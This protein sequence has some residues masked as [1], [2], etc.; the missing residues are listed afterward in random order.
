MRNKILLLLGLSAFLVPENATLSIMLLLFS[1]LVA[2]NKADTLNK[3]LTIIIATAGLFMI[4]PAPLAISL[5]TATSL[6]LNHSIL[7]ASLVLVLQTSL[8]GSCEAILSD[9][10]YKVHLEP[11]A[12]SILVGLFLV[13]LAPK[14]AVFNSLVLALSPV[15]IIIF[16]RSMP[17][18]SWLM[19]LGSLPVFYIAQRYLEPN[20]KGANLGFI[21]LFIF[22]VSV[23]WIHAFPRHTSDSYLVIPEASSSPEYK[24]YE[25]YEAVTKFTG[26]NLK[27]VSAPEDI[28][29]NSLVLLPWLTEGFDD[30]DSVMT[31]KI[32]ELA[33]Q[34]K[35]TVIL[36]GEHTNM[37]GVAERINLLTG[38]KN[39]RDDLT[40]PPGNTDANGFLR[41]STVTS[42]PQSALINR[43]A[44]VKINSIF[45]KILLSG[46]GWWAEKNI[47]EWLWVGDYIW[48][49]ADR[50]GRLSLAAS[51][52]DDGAHWII[53]G[54]STPF[55]NKAL[56][57]D[58]RPAINFMMLS[59][60]WS[61]FARDILLLTL[62]LLG[63]LQ[64]LKRREGYLAA[65]ILTAISLPLFIP[66]TPSSWDY[67]WIGENAFMESNFNTQL[68]K[69][70]QLLESNWRLI[71]SPR[72][73]NESF[74]PENSDAVI[75]G[76]VENNEKINGI[77]FENC[78][79]IG[80]VQTDE[81]PQL[82][83]AQACKITGDAK[84]LI[85]SKDEAA[86]IE[87]SSKGKK[88]IVVLDQNFLSQGAKQANIDWL[89]KSISQET[90]Q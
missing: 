26:L 64:T 50:S 13:A 72:L 79:R 38:G 41:N 16:A 1:T 45:D 68:A 63:A 69:N 80:N 42:W 46:D 78:R 17:D 55:L 7:S 28:P 14:K 59:E 54:D 60:M 2:L 43:G 5:I 19:M 10:L 18:P 25:N 37:N 23:S 4:I 36:V 88:I 53:L 65:L 77:T 24:Y 67:I 11:A 31:M 56:L 86:A 30:D 12:P 83:N 44:S 9:Y 90:Y 62:A 49:P 47:G 81:G 76:L 8:I 33:N 75:F 71:R 73:I 6:I 22:L 35:W 51:I 15:L 3:V 39:L 85:G 87:F 48:Q 21:S 29:N 20:K 61:T 74:L 27:K 66:N 40:V 89:I 52:T 58:P 82:M 57:A 70:K 84:A 34:R 32:K